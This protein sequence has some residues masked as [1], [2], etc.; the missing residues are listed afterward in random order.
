MYYKT[1]LL[2]YSEINRV[3]LYSPLFSVTTK[4]L[5]NIQTENVRLT[6]CYSSGIPLSLRSLVYNCL[7]HQRQPRKRNR[8]CKQKEFSQPKVMSLA[9]QQGSLT[10]LLERI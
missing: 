6:Y 1:I 7:D 10:T 2:K 3:K 5:R 4:I 9:K 8:Y